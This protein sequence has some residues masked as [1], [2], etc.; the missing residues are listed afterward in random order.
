MVPDLS[1]LIICLLVRVYIILPR[2]PG[3]P[4]FQ[5]GKQG[6]TLRAISENASLEETR[7]R[8]CTLISRAKTNGLLISLGLF[9]WWVRVSA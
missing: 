6:I 9:R 3:I 4:A 8:G 7:Q 2:K 5:K 1:T